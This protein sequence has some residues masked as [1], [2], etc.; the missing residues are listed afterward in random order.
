MEFEKTPLYSEFIR[1]TTEGNTEASYYW[2]AVILANGKEITTFK[3][4]DMD[5]L[6]DYANNFAD[7]MLVSV[8]MLAGDYVGD[9][10]P[11]REDLQV[12]LYKT[13]LAAMYGNSEDNAEPLVKMTYKGI[14][15]STVDVKAHG[16]AGKPFDQDAMNLT[17]PITVEFDLVRKPIMQVR[18]ITYGQIFR[19]VVPGD[20]VKS[21]LTIASKEITGPKDE[22]VLGMTMV[23]P[24]NK[25]ETDHVII[26]QGTPLVD[27]PGYVQKNCN[28]IYT[29]GIG[30]YV[31]GNYWYV[32]AP[33]DVTRY[34]KVQKTITLIRI[35]EKRFEGLDRT[36]SLDG[37]NLTIL[38]P[39]HFSKSDTTA[40]QKL[41]SG[42]G[43]M[44]ADAT[45][46]MSDF[47][48]VKDNKATV[49]RKENNNEFTTENRT[50]GFSRTLRADN[51]ITC[52]LCVEQSK[53]SIRSGSVM[54]V[55]WSHSDP[56]LIEP[57]MPVKIMVMD[58]EELKEIE[59]VVLM[60][61]TQYKL[62]G[63]GAA[64]TRHS[65]NTALHIFYK[66]EP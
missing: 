59:G 24:N 39:G 30:F 7:V 2:T 20:T 36:W 3:V 65:C 60:S 22:L 46:F 1:I 40:V 52:N 6:R 17:P 41:D 8:L 58:G 66:P 45:K 61:D 28:G 29:N 13:P 55:V 38:A 57:C 19:K 11:Y 5:I 42:V 37:D 53:L 62:H 48:Q 4:V 50:D 21:I 23:E 35:P 47:V 32:Y 44:F 56:E 18:M 10:Y 54:T 31:Q 15:K 26:P 34:K 51:R 14:L 9:V 49:S 64:A 27:I 16:S 25:V 12:V 33:F 63:V 43:V